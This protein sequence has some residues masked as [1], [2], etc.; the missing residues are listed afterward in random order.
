MENIVRKGEIT[1]NKQFLLFSPC[2]L[3]YIAFI[4]HFKCT[5]K[6]RLKFVSIWT[7]LKFCRLVMGYRQFQENCRCQC[8]CSCF[9]C[10]FVYLGITNVFGGI[11]LS[12]PPRCCPSVH[13]QNISNFV[14]QTPATILLLLQYNLYSETTQGK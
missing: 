2:F 12:V 14:S 1:F 4:F 13:V 11:R 9:S 5:I 6:C 7:S 10:G 8:I 3:T